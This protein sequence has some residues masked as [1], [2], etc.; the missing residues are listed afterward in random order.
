MTDQEKKITEIMESMPTVS[1][2]VFGSTEGAD[3]NCENPPERASA[4][5]A[6]SKKGLG[7]GEITIVADVTGQTYIDTEHMDAATV[8]EILC[9]LVDGA[10][11]DVDRDPVRHKQYN[12]VMKSRCGDRCKVCNAK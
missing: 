3:P 2:L 5:I 7:F 1:R 4:V 10:I 8:K 9:A 12:E 11:L 6:F